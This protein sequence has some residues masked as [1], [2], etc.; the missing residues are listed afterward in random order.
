M[1]T[2]SWYSPWAWPAFPALSVIDISFGQPA[3]G[4]F[5]YGVRAAIVVVL[6]IWN[7]SVWAVIFI[8]MAWMA[9]RLSERRL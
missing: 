6:M 5:S 8:L 3:F 4:D 1:T 2:F 9:G 7:T